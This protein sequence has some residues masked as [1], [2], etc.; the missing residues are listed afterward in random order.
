MMT[1][2]QRTM[3]GVPEMAMPGA[4]LPEAGIVHGLN[5]QCW[6]RLVGEHYGLPMISFRDA[7]WPEIEAGH[8][9]WE[10]VIADAVHPNDLGHRIA[11][12]CVIRFLE[13]VRVNLP[14]D[15]GLPEIRPIPPPRFSSRFEHVGYVR[16]EDL[17]PVS[18]DGWRLEKGDW[19]GQW[20]IC[21]R[22]GAAVEFEFEGTGVVAVLCLAKEHMG[23][24]RFRVDDGPWQRQKGWHGRQ[25]DRLVVVK[26]LADGLAPGRHTLRIEMTDEKDPDG[27]SFEF[28]IH[29]VAATGV[30]ARP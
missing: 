14:E 23:V 24:A 13:G 18:N 10:D 1:S 25:W 4:K 19:H 28:R 26:D 30:Q 27:D 20:W 7:V 21:R 17:N 5:V 22:P 2:K 9:T 8:W 11:A 15:A 6:H 16:A 29:A 3:P 12:D